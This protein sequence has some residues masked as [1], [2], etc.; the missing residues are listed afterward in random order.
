M[1]IIG[2]GVAGFQ[3]FKHSGQSEWEKPVGFLA[4]NVP[5]NL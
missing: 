1:F 2:Y 3:R 5:L 4:E